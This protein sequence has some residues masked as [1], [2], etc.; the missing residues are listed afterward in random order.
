[1]NIVEQLRKQDLESFFKPDTPALFKK[2]NRPNS[3]KGLEPYSGPWNQIT[4]K[5]LLNRSLFGYRKS[6]LQGFL[7]GSLSEALSQLIEYSPAAEEPVKDYQGYI[8]YL[9]TLPEYQGANAIQDTVGPGESWI[10]EDRQPGPAG[11]A[12]TSARITSLK[13]WWLKNI[14]TQEN[15]LEEKMLFFWHN[16]LVTQSFGV[17]APAFTYRYIQT[18][19]Q[20]ATG[21]FRNLI[22]DITTDGAMLIYLN[23]FLSTR[24]GPDE[25]YARE[26]QE[27]FTVGKGPNSEYTES[28]VREMAR[29]LTGW[30]INY[31]TY[32]VFF[33]PLNHDPGEKQFSE[34]YGNRTITGGNT[35]QDAERELNE[36]IDMILSTEECAKYICRRLYQFFV[37]PVIDDWTENNIIVDLANTL[38]SNDYEI[39]PVLYQLLGSQ[40]FFDEVNHAAQIKSPID[41]Y[42]SLLK[43]TELDLRSLNL[44]PGDDDHFYTYIS[45]FYQLSSF[46]L[47]LGDPP[48]VSGWPPYYQTPNYDYLWISSSTVK[49]RSSL[50]DGYAWWGLWRTDFREEPEIEP[51][52]SNFISLLENH[53][54]N[55]SDPN[56][57]IAELMNNFMIYTENRNEKLEYLKSVL[58]TGQSDDAYWTDAWSNYASEPENQTFLEEVRW[59]LNSMMQ[60][61]FLLP[62][63][64]LH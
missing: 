10:S 29:V 25:N 36:L 34:F 18:L 43:N 62:D 32:E 52:Y 17:F 7:Q 1:M 55:P 44:E 9:N 49:S 54:D 63:Y 8:D 14:L 11:T 22:R 31:E 53:I 26:L 28:D 33:V 3:R 60:R 40:H 42:A 51:V 47:Q 39:K 45:F 58:L 13:A 20:H 16:I 59:R 23:G 27:L 38:R 56:A 37:Y 4:V 2:T 12:L 15:T 61:F 5:H 6:D 48:S 50:S 64:Q 30:T 35:Q 24:F 19:R 21:N 41:F 46:G 57:L